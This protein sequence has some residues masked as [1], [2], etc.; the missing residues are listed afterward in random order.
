MVNV[1]VVRHAHS[2]GNR[3]GIRQGQVDFP[4][5]EKGLKQCKDLPNVL[6]EYDIEKVY[7]SDLRRAS[8]TVEYSGIRNEV[9]TEPTEKVR[10]MDFGKFSGTVADFDDETA[11]PYALTEHPKLGDGWPNGE[12]YVEFYNRIRAFCHQLVI[13]HSDDET[14][15][16]VMHQGSLMSLRD[17]AHNAIPLEKQYESVPNLGGFEFEMTTDKMGIDGHLTVRE[18]DPVHSE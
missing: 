7:H 8:E 16:V 5:S 9:P 10:E 2:V 6:S 3:F 1:I 14:V 12:R 11:L 18:K 13:D 17:L 15:A 4:L